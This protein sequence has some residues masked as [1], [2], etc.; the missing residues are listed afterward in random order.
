MLCQENHGFI[1]QRGLL[2]PFAVGTIDQAL[3]SVMN[4]RHSFVRSFG[5][6]GKVV[7]IDEVHTYDCYTGSI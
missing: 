1:C 2:Y 5:L 6:A 3:L 4:V 7:I